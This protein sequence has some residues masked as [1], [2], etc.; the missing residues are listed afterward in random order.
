VQGGDTVV[1]PGQLSHDDAG[2][3]IGPAPVD[4]LGRN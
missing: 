4:A 1:V 2:S 3:L